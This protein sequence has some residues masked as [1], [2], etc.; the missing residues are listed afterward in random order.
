MCLTSAELA[1]SSRYQG[2]H[3]TPP[4]LDAMI[5][6][7][8]PARHSFRAGFGVMHNSCSWERCW[9]LVRGR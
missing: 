6:V 4:L 1:H 8:A 5:L 7:L 9:P 2:R 3:P